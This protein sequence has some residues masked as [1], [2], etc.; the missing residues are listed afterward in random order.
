MS[1]TPY[2][3][4]PWGF[5]KIL[6]QTTIK[7]SGLPTDEP[8]R[9]EK[10]LVSNDLQKYFK[11]KILL[12]PISIFIRFQATDQHLI[13]NKQRNTNFASFVGVKTLY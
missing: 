5:L 8:S 9:F 1:E 13:I 4:M 2:K 6:G 10:N 12:R 7:W 11:Q 3:V